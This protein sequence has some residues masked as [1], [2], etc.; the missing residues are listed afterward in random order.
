MLYKNINNRKIF[1]TIDFEDLYHDYKRLLNINE[2]LGFK[3]H[4]LWQSYETINYNLS[5]LKKNLKITFFCTAIIA[6]E[7][8]DLIKKISNDGH[9]I[10]CHYYFHDY[11]NSDNL[12]LFEKNLNLSIDLL[13]KCSSNKIVGFRAPYFSLDVDNFEYYK[14]LSKYFLYDSSLNEIE[15]E[16]FRFLD[17]KINNDLFFFPVI[18]FKFLRL[19][20][21]RFG[22]SFFKILN[23]QLIKNI[24]N[25]H[26]KKN[27]L[28][29]I[30]LHPYEF[31]YNK[32]FFI[33]YKSFYN[34]KKNK[35][36]KYF[37]QYLWS[38]LNKKIIKNLHE[39]NKNYE[40]GGSLMKVLN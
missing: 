23:K 5:C 34:I 7:F 9:E 36:T 31:D 17:S 35:L 28:P 39:I 32:S 20:K 29:I 27:L 19:L 38:S 26:L 15:D 10:A 14:I 1:L 18:N 4:A 22:G 25:F 40:L 13:T 21:F 8:P 6:K 2:N 30:Y 11:V 37:K 16:K 33:P 3:E 12:L 24:Y